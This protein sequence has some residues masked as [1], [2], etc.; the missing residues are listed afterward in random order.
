MATA[1][2]PHLLFNPETWDLPQKKRWDL[3][4][5]EVWKCWD[6]SQK[7][8]SHSYDYSFVPHLLFNLRLVTKK[9]ETCHTKK[10][11]TCHL[12]PTFFLTLRLV[13]KRSL[14]VLRL[15]TKKNSHSYGH[16]KRAGARIFIAISRA[17]SGFAPRSNREWSQLWPQKKIPKNVGGDVVPPYIN[18]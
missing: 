5:K 4:Q 7:K 10:D 17:C 12:F 16:K 1:L 14:K 13:T 11:E 15:V 3:S 9:D 18:Y 6:L 8:N 2:F